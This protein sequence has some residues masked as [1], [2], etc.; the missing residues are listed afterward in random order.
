MKHLAICFSL[1]SLLTLATAANRPDVLVWRQFLSNYLPVN[2]EVPLVLSAV[3]VGDQTAHDV[4]LSVY[5][6]M[7]SNSS[8][9]GPLTVR[10][11]LS[12]KF[13][14]IQPGEKVQHVVRVLLNRIPQGQDNK[15]PD[16]KAF[17]SIVASPAQVIYHGKHGKTYVG[18]SHVSQDKL[19]VQVL[20]ESAV[21]KY[22]GGN[23]W[24]WLVFSGLMS[25]TIG[26]PL[27]TVCTFKWKYDD[28]KKKRV[29]KD[30]NEEDETTSSDND[31][32]KTKTKNKVDPPAKQLYTATQ[33]VNKRKRRE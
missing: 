13:S 21:Q 32:S 10:G 9:T 23:G 4:T 24:Y 3:N 18:Y 8:S 16:Q 6:Q 2:H 27:L 28:Q 31:R 20:L 11:V 12:V 7:Y 25:V 30:N 26:L 19:P 33:V 14:K 15:A 1:L 29:K 17:M 5:R 22:I